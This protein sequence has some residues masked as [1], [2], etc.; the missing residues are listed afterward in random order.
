M[1]DMTYPLRIDKATF[2]KYLTTHKPVPTRDMVIVDTKS[3]TEFE[4]YI[5]Q[6]TP[7]PELKTIFFC[8]SL[9]LDTR[10]IS[11]VTPKIKSEIKTLSKA[12]LDSTI[13]KYHPVIATTPITTSPVNP[14]QKI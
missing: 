12:T 1:I 5:I 14:I 4:N 8:A 2:F 11:G 7:N 10:L 3:E 13:A 6:T 9:H